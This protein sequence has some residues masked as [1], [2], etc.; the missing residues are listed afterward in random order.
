MRLAFEKYHARFH[1]R[2]GRYLAPE[3][4]A[5]DR[6]VVVE[7]KD[8][9]AAVTCYDS[10]EYIA[11]RAIRQANAEAVFFDAIAPKKPDDRKRHTENIVCLKWLAAGCWTRLDNALG[12]KRTDAA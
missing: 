11:A 10:P 6:N 2:G 8:F 9:A 5:R 3:G 12:D 4:V 1:V 7:F